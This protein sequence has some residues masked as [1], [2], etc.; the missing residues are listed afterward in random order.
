[1]FI[2]NYNRRTSF[3]SFLSRSFKEEDCW[4]LCCPHTAFDGKFWWTTDEMRIIVISSF[5]FKIFIM[6]LI[7]CQHELRILKKISSRNWYQKMIAIRHTMKIHHQTSTRNKKNGKQVS[8]MFLYK[9]QI[10]ALW[11]IILRR[12]WEMQVAIFL[13]AKVFVSNGCVIRF[14]WNW[15]VFEFYVSK[16]FFFYFICKILIAENQDWNWGLVRKLNMIS[17]FYNLAM[18]TNEKLLIKIYKSKYLFQ[19]HFFCPKMQ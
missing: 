3:F 18:Q 8:I 14:I 15:I 1:M 16:N 2:S 12:L 9:Q 7:F 5:F 4:I 11:T 6:V 19:F 17:T 10:A 13:L